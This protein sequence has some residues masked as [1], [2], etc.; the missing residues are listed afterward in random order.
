MCTVQINVAFEYSYRQKVSLFYNEWMKSYF[1]QE[2]RNKQ[3]HKG[4]DSSIHLYNYTFRAIGILTV[5]F[6][7]PQ[8]GSDRT[9][10]EN[11]APLWLITWFD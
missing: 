7:E 9:F 8:N 4:S 5:L 11:Y 6:W 1:T 10:D 3:A 2:P